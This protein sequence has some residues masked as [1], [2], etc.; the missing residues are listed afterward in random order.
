MFLLLYCHGIRQWFLHS[1]HDGYELETKQIKR[2]YVSVC[3]F[4]RCS[5]F[6]FSCVASLYSHLNAMK[7]S[8]N[9][10]VIKPLYIHTNTLAPHLLLMIFSV[11]VALKLFGYRDD[12]NNNISTATL[13]IHIHSIWIQ[14]WFEF[15][16]YYK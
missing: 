8:T 14:S 4:G 13:L 6:S 16:M 15:G 11:L 7:R 10:R 1:Y 5:F 12:Y 9:T 2:T 3:S